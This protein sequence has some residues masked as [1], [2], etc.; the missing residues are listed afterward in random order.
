MGHVNFE[1]LALF[2]QI[3]FNNKGVSG[4]VKHLVRIARLIQSQR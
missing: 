2:E 3:L 4:N 1:K